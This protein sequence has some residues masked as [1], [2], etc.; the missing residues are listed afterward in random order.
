MHSARNFRHLLGS[1]RANHLHRRAARGGKQQPHANSDEQQQK[2]SKNDFLLFV[3][4]AP[5]NV[6]THHSQP[7]PRL[8]SK[9]VES[10][11]CHLSMTAS[12]AALTVHVTSLCGWLSLFQEARHR[13]F[14]AG[15]M[16][17][18]RNSASAWPSQNM[19]SDLP[20]CRFDGH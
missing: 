8:S 13:L 9:P 7:S 14:C 12:S 16:R 17:S 20:L 15:L 2:E 10:R 3:H 19:M 1:Q 5:G 6:I 18:W 11:C 4:D